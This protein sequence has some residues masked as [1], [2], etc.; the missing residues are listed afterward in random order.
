MAGQ[1]SEV[2]L[3]LQTSSNTSPAAHK[4]AKAIGQAGAS[5]VATSSLN[6]DVKSYGG[7]KLARGLE[8]QRQA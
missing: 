2:Q 8:K 7:E 1:D 6:I 3:C 5:Y 4:D